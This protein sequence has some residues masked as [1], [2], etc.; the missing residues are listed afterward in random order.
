MLYPGAIRN[1]VAE[2]DLIKAIPSHAPG[3]HVPE[4]YISFGNKMAGY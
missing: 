2:L 3:V 1:G 4:I